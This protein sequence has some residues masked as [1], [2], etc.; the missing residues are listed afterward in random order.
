MRNSFKPDDVTVLLSDLTGKI[1]AQDNYE[2]EL[3]VQQGGHYADMLPKE[4]IPSP[5]Y[6]LEYFNILDTQKEDTAR[7]IWN[8]ARMIKE[9]WESNGR[10]EIVLVS[11]ARAGTPVGVLLRHALKMGFGIDAPHYTISIIHKI[12]IDR[13]AMKT[14]LSQHKF[15][16]ICFVDGWVGKG[17]IANTLTEAMRGYSEFGDFN[18]E[19][20]FAVISDPAGVTNLCGTRED[21]L[22]PVAC[23]NGPIAGLMSRTIYRPD[24]AGEDA[25]H[26]AVYL[27]H[28]EKFDAT[29]DFLD[30]MDAEI[31]KVI[32]LYEAQ[33]SNSEFV[34][35][36]FDVPA[37][38]DTFGRNHPA[39]LLEELSKEYDISDY[40]RIKPSIGETTRVLLRRVPW[41]ILLD[42][43]A[44]YD[45]VSHILIL[46]RE[47][48]V[49]CVT[50]SLYPY[51]VCGLVKDLVMVEKKG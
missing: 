16:D 33:T 3:H 10:D 30:T 39:R 46:A 49:P 13:A 24:L 34:L 9:K 48:G 14:I 15:D 51:K 40:G 42:P 6:I 1:E 44:S 7:Y 21:F 4:A 8:L 23:L 45:E 18:V 27:E 12:G 20:R 22:L 17:A 2:R 35:S 28:M 37:D 25:Y 41:K 50:H 36:D 29:Q 26:S 11:L 47:K 32:K 38:L 5:N 19:E 43:S 31:A